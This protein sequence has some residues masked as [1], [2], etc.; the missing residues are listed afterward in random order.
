MN[1]QNQQG[2]L[3]EIDIMRAIGIIAVVII[4]VTGQARSLPE[5]STTYLFFAAINYSLQFAVPLFLLISALVL[6]YKYSSNNDFDW[7][8]FYRNRIGSMLIPYVIWSVIYL[9][10]KFVV[11]ISDPVFKAIINNKATLD[12]FLTKLDRIV[13]IRYDIYITNLNANNII[14]WGKGNYHLYFLSLIIQFYILFPLLIRCFR[15]IQG[16][17]AKILNRIKEGSVSKNLFDITNFV[18]IT[19]ILYF[20]QY[21]FILF[22]K[23]YIYDEFQLTG[24]LLMSYIMP[25]GMGLWVGYNLKNSWSRV[26]RVIRYF[27]YPIAIIS[28]WMFVQL[29]LNNTFDKDLIA[30][31][32]NVFVTSISLVIFDMARGILLIG[33]KFLK[34]T[35]KSIGE[36]SF[37]IFLIHPLFLELW[38]VNGFIAKIGGNIIVYTLLKFTAFIIVF[39]ISW[40]I[41]KLLGNRPGWRILFGNRGGRKA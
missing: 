16:A 36:A 17:H 10:F 9:I 20:L 34:S 25:I 4:H 35:L 15:F 32:R 22:N 5:T 2:W 23:Q 24:S 30:M 33:S 6:T 3:E 21:E 41:V 31:I 8:K 13:D 37:G 19:F 28:S 27:V 11:M 40:Y 29:S 7:L 1:K 12:I 38:N 26:W 14:F 39:G 18:I